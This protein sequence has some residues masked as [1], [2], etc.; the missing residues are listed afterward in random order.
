MCW[1]R[2]CDVIQDLAR[3]RSSLVTAAESGSVVSM[4]PAPWP[5]PDPQVAAA[6]A[7]KYRGSRPRPLAVLIRGHL[8]EGREEE[9]F[10]AASGL[11]GRPGGSPRRLAPLSAL[12]R[13]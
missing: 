9:E 1:G 11:P 13:A 10:S 8:G 2:G 3:G 4:Q 7:A 5:E 6:I 12:S